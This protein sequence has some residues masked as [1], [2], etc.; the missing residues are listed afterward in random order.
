MHNGAFSTL[1]DVIW[2]HLDPEAALRLY[3]V[4]KLEPSLQTTVKQDSELFAT[5]FTSLDP[6][7]ER[8]RVMSDEDIDYLLVFLDA[9]TSPSALDLKDSRPDAVPSGLAFD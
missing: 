9:L 6:R 4:A 8:A 1:E 7:L 5:L 2:Q 3:D